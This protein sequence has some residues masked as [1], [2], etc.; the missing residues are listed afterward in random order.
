MAETIL[1]LGANYLFTAV[2]TNDKT[3]YGQIDNLP[4]EDQGS[5][6]DSYEMKNRGHGRRVTAE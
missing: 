3:P 5:L 6:S 4:W 1:G 2:K